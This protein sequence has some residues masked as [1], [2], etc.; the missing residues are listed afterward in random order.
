MSLALKK[1]VLSCLAAAA[2]TVTASAQTI[3]QDIPWQTFQDWTVFQSRVYKGCVATAS[4]QNGTTV[5]L[6]FDGIIK[7]YFVNFSNQRWSN[8]QVMKIF[9]LEFVLDGSRNFKGF[10]HVIERGGMPTFETGEIKIAFLD[11][12][13]AAHSFRIREDGTQLVALSLSGSR[14]ALNSMIDCERARN[15][16]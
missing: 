16:R 7:S 12:L 8:Y 5:R 11:A 6:G 2:C 9:E 14:R 13:A 15:S 3:E 10:F 4:Y 1:S